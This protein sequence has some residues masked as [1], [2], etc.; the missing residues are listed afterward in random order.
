MGYN[1]K[2]NFM[3]RLNPDFNLTQLRQGTRFTYE[4]SGERLF[5]LNIAIDVCDAD[6]QFIGKGVV[7][8]LT[9]EKGKTTIECEMLKIFLPE[10]AK[11]YTTTF[12]SM[13]DAAEK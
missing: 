3:L 10:E 13:E 8:K 5:P 1:L 11:V 7:R 9:L 2:F 12:I 4:A 6:A